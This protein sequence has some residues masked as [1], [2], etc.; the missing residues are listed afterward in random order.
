MAS[1]L[2]GVGGLLIVGLTTMTYA[3]AQVFTHVFVVIS[4]VGLTASVLALVL[5]RKGSVPFWDTPQAYAAACI[6]A[7]LPSAV[8]LLQFVRILLQFA[9]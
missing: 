4:V 2:V 6:G 1:S 3:M 5:A 8:F 7:A 9:P